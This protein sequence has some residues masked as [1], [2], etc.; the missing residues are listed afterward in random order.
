MTFTGKRRVN[1]SDTTETVIYGKKLTL[2]NAIIL[3]ANQ[4]DKLVLW[5]YTSAATLA[6]YSIALLVPNSLVGFSNLIPQLALPKFSKRN[7]CDRQEQKLLLL[8]LSKAGA[9]LFFF[10]LIYLLLIPIFIKLAFPDYVFA[11]PAAYLT[12]LIIILAPI[13]NILKQVFYANQNAR[14]VYQISWF[15]LLVLI[16]LMM[17]YFELGNNSLILFALLLPIKQ[18]LGIGCSL[19]FMRFRLVPKSK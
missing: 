16:A 8:K 18:L 3:L 6:Y 13:Q 17:I 12:G 4:I 19:W 9:V 15:E 10:Y 5:H 7:W 1:K 11:I 2:S 14:Y